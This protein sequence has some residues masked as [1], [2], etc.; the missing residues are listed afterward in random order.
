MP[1]PDYLRAPYAGH[2]LV[3]LPGLRALIS[4]LATPSD[5]VWYLQ[6]AEEKIWIADYAAAGV[7][8]VLAGMPT[9]ERAPW[10][11]SCRLAR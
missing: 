2:R 5:E 4:R 3:P 11:M 6:H 10:G 1:V 9:K 8:S 7:E